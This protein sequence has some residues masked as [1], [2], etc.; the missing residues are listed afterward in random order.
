MTALILCRHGRTDWN[1]L[2]RYQG[3]TDVPLNDEG[4]RQAR[5]L[6]ELLHT[7][8]IAAVYA[9][10][11]SRAA[12]TA[13]AIARLHALPVR[14]DPRLRE[15]H[16][17]EWEG[18]TVAEIH[19]RDRELHARWEA[20]P[21]S[22]TL[23]GGESIADVRQR[24]LAALGDMVSAHP[25]ELVCVVTHKIVLTILRCELTGE[26]LEPALRRLP[27]NASFEVVEVPPNLGPGGAASTGRTGRE[28]RSYFK[29]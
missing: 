14:R 27:A 20:A 15:I 9:S 13:A 5:A 8:P 12:D 18:L 17:G 26:P 1:D 29:S 11:L 7:E 25:S 22:V 10:D 6:A 28:R 23:P 3:Q 16:Q 24:A 19:L 4:C 21:L 2:G